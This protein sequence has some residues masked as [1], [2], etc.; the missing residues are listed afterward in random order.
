ME[1]L[2]PMN[3]IVTDFFDDLKQ[4]TSGYGSFDYE[5]AGYK[6]GQLVK[7]DILLNSKPIEELSVIVHGRKAK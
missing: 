6:E 1:Y 2:L 4:C 3:E 5:D 7:I